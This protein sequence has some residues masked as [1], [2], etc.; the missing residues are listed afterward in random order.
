VEAEPRVEPER[1]RVRDH[2]DVAG[3]GGVCSRREIVD[4][5]ATDAPPHPLWLDEEVIK[6]AP[7]VVDRQ[8]RRK[9]EPPS[10]SIDGNTYSSFCD[11]LMRR[12]DRVRMSRELRAVLLPDIGCPSL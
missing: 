8:Y 11:R 9:P 7:A 3:S 6:L 4:K 10:G 1:V 2:V 12:H 5:N